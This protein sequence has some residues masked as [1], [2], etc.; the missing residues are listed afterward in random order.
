[1]HRLAA[2]EVRAHPVAGGAPSGSLQRTLG[3][4]ELLASGVGIIVGAGI[5]VLIGEATQ[6]AGAAVWMSFVLAASLS[7]LTA[8]SYCELAAMYPRAAAEYEYTTHVFPRWF[9]FLV[10]WVMV[11]GLVVAAATVSLGFA[12]YASVF[13]ELDHRVLA[14]ALLAFLGGV[15]LAGVQR[16]SRLTLV[17]SLV[18]V[19]GLLL[20]IAIGVP[21]VGDVSV[22]E[23]RGTG[24]V[25]GAAA[26]VFFAFIGFDEVTTLSEETRQPTRTV[27]LA[28]LASL[29]IS[30]VLYVAVAV[31][32]VSVLGAEALGTSERPLTDVLATA[33][34][35]PAGRLV[36]V[37]AI[38]STTNTTL[39]ALTA[40]S[41]MVFGMARDGVLPHRLADTGG[42]GH[43]PL[44]GIL[45][46]TVGAACFALLGDLRM[47]AA[48]TDVAV[49][50]VF[51][52]TNATL[53]V[54]RFTQPGATRPFKT[55][56]SIA[57]LP[58]IPVLAILG[59]LVMLARLEPSALLGMAALALSGLA[60]PIGRA[61]VRRVLGRAD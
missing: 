35:D 24:A 17:F 1:M 5:Y 32:A 46:C 9:A 47:V 27:P 7:A 50:F 60:L 19:A 15:A 48:T 31:T 43:A 45:A 40:G 37:I 14:V 53:I 36:A 2:R 39:L 59:T 13:F 58:V 56:L 3:F 61:V 29:A 38:V 12:Q 34:G 42:G 10:G 41:R 22:M 16:S 52:A 44:L 33:L 25:V 30:T 18:Q 8:L 51:L 28:L 4:W 6:Q 21:H 57:R 54:L 26:L 20:V 55:P 49:Y 11:V 23:T